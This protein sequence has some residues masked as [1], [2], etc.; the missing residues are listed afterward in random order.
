[1]SGPDYPNINS[2]TFVLETPA[3]PSQIIT[4]IASIYGVLTICQAYSVL[5][6]VTHLL[7]MTT[8]QGMYDSYCHIT[9]GEKLNRSDIKERSPNPGG[10]RI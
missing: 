10:A 4:I 1:M 6:I 2:V 5:H 3:S 7:F 8:L 9:N